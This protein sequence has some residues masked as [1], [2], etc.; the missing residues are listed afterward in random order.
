MSEKI[1]LYQYVFLHDN[2]CPVIF[3]TEDRIFKTV[4]D[5]L[6][7]IVDFWWEDTRKMFADFTRKDVV[8]YGDLVG[9][10][11][12]QFNEVSLGI[13]ADMPSTAVEYLDEINQALVANEVS[14][15]FIHRPVHCRLLTAVPEGIP[16]FS[17]QDGQW[18]NRPFHR[19]LTFSGQE[20]CQAFAD[21]Q[22]NVHEFV[23]KLPKLENG[24]LTIESCHALEDF[25]DKLR[26]ENREA[27]LHSPEHEASL[28][29][30]LGRTFKEIGGAKY[31]NSYLADSYNYN[32]NVLE[33]C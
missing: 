15:K 23:S 24:F 30:L 31:F 4:T 2:L 28:D 10:V 7:R 20:L 12:N 8:I 5:G 26:Q 22:N 25:L 3:E 21:Y 18:I 9:Y 29:Y 11:Y 32:I 6:M 1:N 19:P 17:L 27:W 13:V 33:Q 14:Y 16:A